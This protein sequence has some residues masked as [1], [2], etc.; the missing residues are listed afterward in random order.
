MFV[1]SVAS[2]IFF[3]FFLLIPI[4]SR[5]SSLAFSLIDL[6]PN[7]KFSW[8]DVHPGFLGFLRMSMKFSYCLYVMSSFVPR[9]PGLISEVLLN[10]RRY[11]IFFSLWCDMPSGRTLKKRSF[12]WICLDFCGSYG[13]SVVHISSIL[14]S[15]HRYPMV[16]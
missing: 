14:S 1:F 13:V 6:E 5:F 11:H 4:L 8:S 12:S 7:M 15:F 16:S 9:Y 10:S 2:L 3:L